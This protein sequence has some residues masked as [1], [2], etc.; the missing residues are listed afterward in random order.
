MK[1]TCIFIFISIK[2]CLST[3]IKCGNFDKGIEL[4]EFYCSSF[5]VTAPMDCLSSFSAANLTKLEVILLKIG[6]CDPDKV[7]QLVDTFSNLHS[8]DISQ[9]EIKSLDEFDLKHEQLKRVNSSHNQLTEVPMNF[10]SQI[11]KL[12]EV[13][14]SYNE[15]NK[16]NQFPIKLVKIDLSHNKLTSIHRDDFVNLT[17]LEYVDLSYNLITKLDLFYIFPTNNKL[18]TLRLEKNPIKEFDYRFTPL[19]Q[20]GISVHISWK[21]ITRF[22]FWNYEG[23]KIHVIQNSDKEG[24]LQTI[25]G[26]TE[27]H[28]NDMSFE[29]I[30]DFKAVSNQIKNPSE[31]VQC[32][33]SSLKFLELI[34]NFEEQFEIK[35]LERFKNLNG[36]TLKGMNLKKFNMNVL[37]NHKK[38]NS[39]KLS[40]NDLRKIENL[41][42]LDNGE[43][44]INFDISDNRF[45]NIPELLKNLTKNVVELNLSENFVGKLNASTFERFTDMKRLYLK[46]TSLSIDDLKSFEPFE[47]LDDLDISYNNLEKMNLTSNSI[48]FKQLQKLN[49][50]HCQLKNISEFV[51][52]LG[53][54]L[55]KLDLSGNSLRNVSDKIF[56][57]IKIELKVL[58]VSSTQ[59]I[60]AD[61]RAVEHLTK[62][63]NL[64]ISQN[65]LETLNFTSTFRQLHTLHLDGNNLK[66][67]DHLTRTHFPALRFLN[68]SKNKLKCDYL[69]KFVT[70]LKNEYPHLMMFG[71]PWQQ[72]HNDDCHPKDDDDL[73]YR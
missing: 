39:L 53:L 6:G 29:N 54:L 62:L 42:A 44:P 73:D 57:N 33:T 49:I 23:E 15:L 45:E 35:L 32:L 46:N 60:D 18:K 64:D 72:K 67:I 59:L 13:D 63:E 2:F 55:W 21:N 52:L 36:L 25:D 34:G 41:A 3:D 26:K 7:K 16:I 22:M 17:E 19:L 66:Q 14:F 68:M 1:L 5:N 61:F 10:F 4:A 58:N 56:E 71:D 51:N 9:S 30:F 27:L 8:L 70:Q 43:Y 12:I 28:C 40:G 50:A 37:K 24:V 69:T 65:N 48:V 38:L 31:M 47:R 11:P 20:R